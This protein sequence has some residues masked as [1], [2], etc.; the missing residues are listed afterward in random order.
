VS[1]A[2]HLGHITTQRLPVGKISP[3]KYNP[4]KAL[5]PADPEYQKLKRSISE[6]GYADPLIW[7]KRTG[8]LVGGH[9]RFGVMVAEFGVKEVDVVVVDMDD[10]HEKA[11]NIALNKISGSWDETK[12]AEVMAELQNSTEIDEA[13]AGFDADEIDRMFQIAADELLG[14]DEADGDGGDEEPPEPADTQ[15]T[16]G[17][18]R[19][20]IPRAKWETWIEDVRQ[21]AGFDEG[22]IIA[23]I[24]RR[25]K[26]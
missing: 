4:R 12:L 18:Y 19:F 17:S 10:I 7:N 13:V 26:L 5:T 21:E 9:Q 15:A 25:L 24:R 3:A 14:R 11:L 1:L 8:N 16:I 20:T 6:F 22:S 23:E 2:A